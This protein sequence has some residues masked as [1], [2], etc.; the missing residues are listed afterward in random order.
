MSAY[1]QQQVHDLKIRVRKLE[2][3][4]EF[5]IAKREGLSIKKLQELR[6]QQDR[7]IDRLDEEA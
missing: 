7:E 5:N 3:I 1:L 2:H 4:E 6:E